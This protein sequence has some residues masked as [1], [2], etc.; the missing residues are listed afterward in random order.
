MKRFFIFIGTLVVIVAI[1]SEVVLPQILTGMLKNQ[2][3]KWTASDEVSL[4]LDSTPRF[5]IVAG[6]VDK[7][8]GEVKNGRLGELETTELMLNGEAVKV[9]MPAILFGADNNKKQV[10]QIFKSIGKVEL[11][12]IVSEENLKNFLK[13]KFEQLD[14]VTVKMVPDEISATANVNIMGR[15]A[16][17]ELSGIIIADG[18]DLYFRMT[19][20]NVRNTL[21]R[22]VQLDRFFGDIKIVDGNKMPIGLKFESIEMQDGQTVLKAVRN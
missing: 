4:S 13:E 12:G 10:E 21:L 6:Q 1:L 19:K 3:T 7:V 8:Q 2:I 11:T 17:I 14:N 16:D 9:D 18:G 20:L 5:L 15:D 22:H